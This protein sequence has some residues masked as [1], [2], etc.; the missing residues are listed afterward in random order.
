MRLMILFC[1]PVSHSLNNFWVHWLVSGT[2]DTGQHLS[3]ITFLHILCK[4]RPVPRRK[5]LLEIYPSH[6][7]ASCVGRVPGWL[8]H[9][10]V[11]WGIWKC[12]SWVDVAKSGIV[13]RGESGGLENTEPK[14]GLCRRA[15]KISSCSIPLLWAGTPPGC[16]TRDWMKG[17]QG[18]WLYCRSV[19]EMRMLKPNQ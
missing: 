6:R 18:R 5:A 7:S 2:F 1:L 4:S 11:T 15:P 16:S 8:S 14:N 9:L 13:G 12:E 3:D 19:L 10:A 17:H